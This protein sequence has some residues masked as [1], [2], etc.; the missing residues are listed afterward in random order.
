MS[1]NTPKQP[2]REGYRKPQPSLRMPMRDQHAERDE[3]E[4]RAANWICLVMVLVLA[5]V[6]AAVAAS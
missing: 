6:V 3:A 2:W 4:E 5:A 1:P